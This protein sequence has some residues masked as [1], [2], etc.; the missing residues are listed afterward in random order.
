MGSVRP[1]THEGDMTRAAIPSWS[2]ARLGMPTELRAAPVSTTP[3]WSRLVAPAASISRA[4]WSKSSAVRA[5]MIAPCG[6]A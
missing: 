3:D 5:S 6:A 4:T 2:R 1:P